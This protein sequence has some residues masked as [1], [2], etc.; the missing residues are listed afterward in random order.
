MIKCKLTSQE[1]RRSI[2]KSEESALISKDLGKQILKIHLY[3]P[4]RV[5]YRENIVEDVFIKGS[6]CGKDDIIFIDGIPDKDPLNFKEIKPF[7]KDRRYYSIKYKAHQFADDEININLMKINKDSF[8]TSERFLKNCSL[9]KAKEYGLQG[10]LSSERE[11]D[12]LFF[13]KRTNKRF[14]PDKDPDCLVNTYIIP[15]NSLKSLI[16]NNLNLIRKDNG[17]KSLRLKQTNLKKLL[18]I[19][20]TWKIYQEMDSKIKKNYPFKLFKKQ[21]KQ[22]G[23]LPSLMMKIGNNNLPNHILINENGYIS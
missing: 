9:G 17:L 6:D 15:H 22:K 14:Y 4:V 5:I 23:Q 13:I 7:N 16:S 10:I 21:D 8:Y 18:G 2:D 12:F 3:D 11:T 19:H 1:I 20:E